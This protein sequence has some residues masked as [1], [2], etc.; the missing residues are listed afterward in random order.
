MS[1][2]NEKKSFLQLVQFLIVGVSNTLVDLIVCYLLQR[3][4]G[5][6]LIAKVIG[7]AC[8]ILNSYFLNSNWTFR[9]EKRHDAKEMLLFAAVNAVTL[10]LSLLLMFLFRDVLSLNAVWEGWL[11]GSWILK[12]ITGEFFCTLLSTGI[13]LVVN[14]LGSKLFVFTGSRNE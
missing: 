12:V 14:F 10:G 11:Q 3:L 2:S 6:Y 8:G 13:T 9:R 5:I 1:R 4:F 7:Y